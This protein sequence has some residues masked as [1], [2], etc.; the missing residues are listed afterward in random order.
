M[1]EQPTEGYGP[2]VI[3]VEELRTAE[4]IVIVQ[5]NGDTRWV[6]SGSMSQAVSR[7]IDTTVLMQQRLQKQLEREVDTDG[8]V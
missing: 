1:S 5:P 4:L 2:T 7:M 6:A 8:G 3:R